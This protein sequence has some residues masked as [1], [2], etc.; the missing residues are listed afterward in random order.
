MGQQVL[1]FWAYSSAFRVVDLYLAT[2]VC[3]GDLDFM[4]NDQG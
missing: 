1:F 2:P 3:I 4:M